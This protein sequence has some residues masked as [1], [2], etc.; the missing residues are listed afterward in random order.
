VRAVLREG[1]GHEVEEGLLRGLFTGAI[2]PGDKKHTRHHDLKIVSAIRRR[3][4]R[5]SPRLYARSSR[6]GS[7]GVVGRAEAAR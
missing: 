2:N 3:P 5:R 7:T 4:W 6:P 1:V